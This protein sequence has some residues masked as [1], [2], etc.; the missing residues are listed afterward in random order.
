[1][2]IINQIAKDY[3][4]SGSGYRIITSQFD[5]KFD[6]CIDIKYNNYSI[7][8]IIYKLIVLR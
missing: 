8:K 2:R 7:T 4:R 6:I 3:R 1:M 5:Y